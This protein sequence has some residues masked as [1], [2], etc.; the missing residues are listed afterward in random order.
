MLQSRFNLVLVSLQWQGGKP[1][2]GDVCSAHIAHS[3]SRSRA[4]RGTRP[5]RSPQSGSLAPAKL[6]AARSF[7]AEDQ[8]RSSTCE[9]R[10]G[11]SRTCGIAGVGTTFRARDHRQ[12]PRF[13]LFGSW[14]SLRGMSWFPLTNDD[15]DESSNSRSRVQFEVSST[16]K[17]ASALL[18][19]VNAHL[20]TC[21]P[22][23][24]NRDASLPPPPSTFKDAYNSTDTHSS[25]RHSPFNHSSPNPVAHGR[26][27]RFRH[28]VQ[29]DGTG[30]KRCAEGCLQECKGTANP[31][32]WLQLGLKR[33]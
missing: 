1:G 8:S 16:R 29:H 25:T 24:P 27:G 18:H 9:Q 4:G 19:Q 26:R 31:W 7:F 17:K 22:L 33:V 28:H 32:A 12:R 30:F 11:T 13:D 21:S 5:P 6:L 23:S 3:P 10:H 2:S 20:T 14:T 15:D